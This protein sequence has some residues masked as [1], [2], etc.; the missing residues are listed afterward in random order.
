MPETMR[1]GTVPPCPICSTPVAR[2]L[3]AKASPFVRA[4][5]RINAATPVQSRFCPACHHVFLT[6]LLKD[7]Q[8]DSLYDDYRSATYDQERTSFEPDY[9]AVALEFANVDSSYHDVRR[10]FY[11]D[12]L[13]ER[14]S[15]RGVVV[16]FG[17][18]DGYFSR[19][20]FPH[21]D[22]VI[23]ERRHEAAGVDL[24]RLLGAADLLMC[25]HVFQTT[26]QPRTI[27]R[28]LVQELRPDVPV[29]VELP[30]QY[31]GSLE[32]EFEIQEHRFARGE[33]SF[34]P[35][36]TLHENLAHFSV[37]SARR[38]MEAAG[39]VVDEVV[40]SD[41]GVMGLL[42]HKPQSAPLQPER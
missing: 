18:G 21:A 3:E 24:P 32:A 40:R 42:G 29:W 12:F 28:G 22:V 34:P 8:L 39:L 38:L 10:R 23:V 7:D 4:R 16:D 20:V 14:F 41:I 26:P 37:R 17:G 1:V 30:V 25:A 2:C 33:R 36:Q 15:T 6:P 5:C 11:D 27:L 31:R 13:W 35:I 19:Y 9:S